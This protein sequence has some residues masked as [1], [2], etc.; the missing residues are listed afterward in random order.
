MER[1]NLA[2]AKAHLSEL[3]T[4][5]SNGEEI[6]IVRR[7]KSVARLLPPEKPRKPFDWDELER[8]TSAMTPQPESAGDFMRKLR[9]SGY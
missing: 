7:G 5:A 8:V 2:D 4:R 6:E 9:D 3:V 1:I